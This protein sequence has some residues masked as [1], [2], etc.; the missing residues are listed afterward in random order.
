MDF[1]KKRNERR[2][3]IK[4]LSVHNVSCNKVKFLQYSFEKIRKRAEI[5]Y[6]LIYEILAIVDFFSTYW[7]RF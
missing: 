5:S 4:Y 1:F 7:F 6:H 2:T 3:S